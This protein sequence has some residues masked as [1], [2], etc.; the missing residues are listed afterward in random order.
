MYSLYNSVGSNIDLLFYFS[1]SRNITMK[2]WIRAASATGFYYSSWPCRSQLCLIAGG[3]DIGCCFKLVL[4]RG[5]LVSLPPLPPLRTIS[6]LQEFPRFYYSRTRKFFDIR[7]L[8]SVPL[9]QSS[10]VAI[11][12]HGKQQEAN[13]AI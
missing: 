1:L 3:H 12:V 5:A 10:T 6:T 8:R 9:V 2:S 4:Y 11:P 7:I 13:L